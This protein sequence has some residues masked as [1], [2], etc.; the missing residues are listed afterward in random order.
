M[1]TPKNECMQFK[2]GKGWVLMRRV[3]HFCHKNY[4][5][6]YSWGEYCRIQVR[7]RLKKELTVERQSRTIHYSSS[8]CCLFSFL[9][10]NGHTWTASVITIRYEQHS[11][12][13]FCS[14]YRASRRLCDI[15][16]GR[17]WYM[18]LCSL[19]GV[20]QRL[21]YLVP[22]STTIEVL[23]SEEGGSSFHR[24]IRSHLSDYTW[25]VL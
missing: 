18:K 4:D 10:T 3:A 1:G 22:Q 21:F 23:N 2:W 5:I 16:T 13:I 15:N 19:T 7:R 9:L 17:L 8:L 14:F 12:Y 6:G 20:L 11:R 25:K 24:N